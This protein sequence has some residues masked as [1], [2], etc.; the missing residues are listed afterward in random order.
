M[1]QLFL[2]GMRM[3]RLKDLGQDIERMW[4]LEIEALNFGVLDEKIWKSD[5]KSAFRD[6]IYAQSARAKELMLECQTQKF[7]PLE[8]KKWPAWA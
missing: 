6:L 2:K 7:V 3:K 8:R 5:V 1:L 4:V